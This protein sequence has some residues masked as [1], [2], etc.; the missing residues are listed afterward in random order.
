MRRYTGRR[1]FGY[2]GFMWFGSRE[3]ICGVR[4]M[5]WNADGKGRMVRVWGGLEWFVVLMCAS[6]TGFLEPFNYFILFD[7]VDREAVPGVVRLFESLSWRL[8]DGLGSASPV[9]PDRLFCSGRTC[10]SVSPFHILRSFACINLSRELSYS[11]NISVF[12]SMVLGP[13]MPRWL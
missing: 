1:G 2:I 3:R 11:L 9:W 6:A 5:G 12:P 8:H 10:W 13:D 7:A 4:G